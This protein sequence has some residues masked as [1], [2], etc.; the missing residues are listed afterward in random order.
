MPQDWRSLPARR[1]VRVGNC[2]TEADSDLATVEPEGEVSI[3]EE[4][5]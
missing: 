4:E 3:E 2:L 1:A 5:V